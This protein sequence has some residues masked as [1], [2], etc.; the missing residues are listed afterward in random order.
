VHGALG[1]AARAEDLGVETLEVE[2]ELLPHPKRP[3]M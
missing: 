2:V 1:L 3:V